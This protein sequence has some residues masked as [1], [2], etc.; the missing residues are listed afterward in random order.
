MGIGHKSDPVMQINCCGNFECEVGEEACSD[1]SGL[2][3]A[4]RTTENRYLHLIYTQV[5]HAY[6][7]QPLA[8]HVQTPDCSSC[9]SA[10]GFMFDIVAGSSEILIDG[11]FFKRNGD[12][13][14]VSIYTV[15]GSYKDS[16]TV[17]GAWTLIVSTNIA[18][19]SEFGEKENQQSFSCAPYS[20]DH[21]CIIPLYQVGVTTSRLNSV[22][23]FL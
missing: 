8:S 19:A 23:R 12:S 13:A 11:L 5:S 2:I 1:C 17:S 4:V 3:L 6:S 21:C 20:F 9:S 7:H 10:S 16:F 22:M 18:S 14:T 15:P